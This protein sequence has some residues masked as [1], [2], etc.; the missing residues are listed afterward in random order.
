MPEPETIAETDCLPDPT[1]APGAAAKRKTT[2]LVVSRGMKLL[3]VLRPVF[4]VVIA[5]LSSYLAVRFT[6][7]GE[8]EKLFEEVGKLQARLHQL[9]RDKAGE[10]LAFRPPGPP[11]P[12]GEKGAMGPTGP[13]SAGPPGLPGE[14]GPR[15]PAGTG[16][17]GPAGP[18]GEKGARG[19][20]GTG[21]AGP[22]GPTG[23]KGSGGPAGSDGKNGP[24]GPRGPRGLKGPVGPPGPAGMSACPSSTGP[25]ERT[26]SCPKGYTRKD[27]VCFK[28]FKEQK[29]FDEATAACRKNGGTLA[30]PRDAET[31]DFLVR[32]YK[33]VSDF[34]FWIG[35]H[36]KQ[37]GFEW[38]D[39][40]ALGFTSWAPRE[41]GDGFCAY[42]AKSKGWKGKWGTVPC[43][44]YSMPFICQVIL[45]PADS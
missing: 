38:V 24:P 21:S 25:T 37:G 43:D 28:V 22:P 14:K 20:P 15:G 18:P 2:S 27:E 8:V 23:E 31:N 26:A 34:G 4:V 3:H 39:G 6:T 32:L 45:G 30:M 19:L 36:R 5:V 29:N 1:Y 13:V 7:F 42:Y 40:S 12:P 33:P 16:S 11:G 9:E 41:P 44:S 17:T 10:A 35:L